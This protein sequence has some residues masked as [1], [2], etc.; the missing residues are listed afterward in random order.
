MLCE[1]V[2][3]VPCSK[4]PGA[5]RRTDLHQ[6]R[7]RALEKRNEVGV[8]SQFPSQLFGTSHAAGR[9]ASGRVE[10][11]MSPTQSYS[12]PH[13]TPVRGPRKKATHE[14]YQHAHKYI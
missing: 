9:K 10:R 3:P 1:L 8:T 6:A 5:Q 13:G 14:T 11:V 4:T 2:G 7:A 12:R